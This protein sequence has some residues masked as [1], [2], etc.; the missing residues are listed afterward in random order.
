VS[1]RLSGVRLQNSYF[2]VGLELIQEIIVTPVTKTSDF[3]FFLVHFINT[4]SS[5]RFVL[6]KMEINGLGCEFLPRKDE[7]A[8]F[9]AI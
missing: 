6:H 8:N 1:A 2:R 3:R 7:T 9:L 4:T 5:K